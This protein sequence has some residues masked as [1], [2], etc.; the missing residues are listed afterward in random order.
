MAEPISNNLTVQGTSDHPV[1]VD[2]T[3]GNQAVLDRQPATG[4]KINENDKMDETRAFIRKPLIGRS[5]PR[6]RTYSLGSELVE[7]RDKKRK[8]ADRE[9]PSEPL[10]TPNIQDEETVKRQQEFNLILKKLCETTLELTNQIKNTRNTKEE[11]KKGITTASDLA[12]KLNKRYQLWKPLDNKNKENRAENSNKTQTCTFCPNCAHE[13]KAEASE[14]NVE[15]EK[16]VQNIRDKILEADNLDKLENIINK[17]WPEET[18]KKVMIE[19]GNPLKKD[20]HWDICIFTGPNDSCEKGILKQLS[21]RHP[22]LPALIEHG[23]KEKQIE[24]LANVTKSSRDRQGSKSKYLFIIPL[25][26]DGEG[27]N[28]PKEMYNITKKLL[29]QTETLQRKN[30]QIVIPEEESREKV[31]KILECTYALTTTN[32]KM[33]VPIGKQGKEQ[34]NETNT[35]R[36]RYKDEAIIIKSN[37]K[38]Y[39]E[40]LSTVKSIDISS[41]EANV[42]SIR[43]TKKGDLLLILPKGEGK[44]D[45]LKREIENKI[46]NTVVQVNKEHKSTLFIT[47]I[48]GITTQEEIEKTIK[49]EIKLEEN[50]QLK[51]LNLIKN[52]RETQTAIIEL[53]IGAA[54]RLLGM[55]YIKIGWLLCEVTPRRKV[56]KCVKCWS[57][58]HVSEKCNGPNRQ[59]CCHKCGEEGHRATEC[60]SQEYCPLCNKTGHRHDRTNCKEY[61]K[62]KS[63]GWYQR[64]RQTTNE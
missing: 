3:V 27:K 41:T 39:A 58:N 55:Q 29:S 46:E 24:Y 63:V 23:T 26:K 61:R 9:D 18:Y 52:Q 34:K 30:I 21:E 8:L 44:A 31:R 5:P 17:N 13:L 37:G 36:G 7:Q 49:N 45:K 35:T 60:N 48:D 57:Y 62:A 53:T 43:K 51:I 59:N 50:E 40:M 11:I 6:H 15:N 42:K 32:I 33:L 47:N 25:T 12:N 38:S 19:E 4:T 28:D 16:E 54:T 20:I 56:T 14:K 2:D 1:P 10:N 22:E 64:R